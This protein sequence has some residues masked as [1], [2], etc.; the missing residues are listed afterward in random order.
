MLAELE[1]EMPP[2]SEGIDSQGLGG[3]YRS[4]NFN[5]SN[6]EAKLV[7]TAIGLRIEV[8]SILP[9]ISLGFSGKRNG[10]W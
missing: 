4:S 2:H 6:N 8:Q 1:E 3:T 9:L 10:D 7:S 5:F